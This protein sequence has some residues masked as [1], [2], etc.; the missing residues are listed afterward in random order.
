MEA[1]KFLV[2]DNTDF[3]D[4]VF[5]I[6]TQTPMFVMNLDTDEVSFLEEGF[7]E[8]DE[9]QTANEITE[10]LAEADEFYNKEVS[11]Y[12]EMED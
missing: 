11:R 1:P 2:G 4:T 12:E 5:I 10:L 9:A 7:A 6:H 8:G 3:P